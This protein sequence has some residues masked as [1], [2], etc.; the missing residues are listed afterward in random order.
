MNQS[1]T[2]QSSLS[3]SN[4]AGINQ[5][6]TSSLDMNQMDMNQRSSSL[7]EM[8][9]VD[10]KQP[11]MSQA[12]MRQSDLLR[13]GFGDN[14]LFYCLIAEVNNQ[15]KPS[16]KLTVGFAMYYFTYDSRTGKVLYLEDFYVTQAY[17]G[18]GI[19]AEM[20]KRL[21]QIAIRTQCN[22]MHFLVVIWNQASINYYTSRGALDLSSKEGWH[23][24]RF[25]REELLDIAWEE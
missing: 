14:P 19:G 6:S 23:L 16:G 7:Y 2:N 17:Q 22:C 1:G 12:G 10:M 24:F 3:D 9:E 18:L 13:D 25:N 15:Q 11:S 5:P 21:S 20:L 8:I 4:Q